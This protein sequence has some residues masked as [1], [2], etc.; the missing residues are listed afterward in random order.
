MDHGHSENTSKIRC[1][2]LAVSRPAR[3]VMGDSGLPLCRVEVV[4]ASLSILNACFSV[5]SRNWSGFVIITGLNRG[6]Q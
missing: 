3:E 5:P 4:P 1:F 2:F 6:L